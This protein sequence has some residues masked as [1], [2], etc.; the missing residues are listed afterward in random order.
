MKYIHRGLFLWILSALSFPACSDCT[1]PTPFV[2]Y[3]HLEDSQLETSITYFWKKFETEEHI[4]AQDP[5]VLREA[6]IKY[7]RMVDYYLSKRP[8]IYD[9]Y[10]IL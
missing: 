5:T 6:Y 10:E 1:G 3:G 2:K 8:G 7:V 4:R 9:K